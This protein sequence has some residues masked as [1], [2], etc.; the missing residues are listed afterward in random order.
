M[1]QEK[2][3]ELIQDFRL[4]SE[5]DREMLLALAHLCAEKGRHIEL[6]PLIIYGVNSGNGS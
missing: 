5:K 2:E 6:S 1:Q 3:V 4:A